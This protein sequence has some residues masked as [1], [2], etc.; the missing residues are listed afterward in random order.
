MAIDG[1]LRYLLCLILIPLFFTSTKAQFTINKEDW[2]RPFTMSK[3]NVFTSV[4]SS[5]FAGGEGITWNIQNQQSIGIQTID[6]QKQ[7]WYLNTDLPDSLLAIQWGNRDTW[8]Y[9]SRNSG[10]HL[11]GMIQSGNLWKADAPSVRIPFPL[12]YGS[13]HVLESTFSYTKDTSFLLVIDSVRRE[14][15]YLQT[16]TTPGYGNFIT[17]GVPKACMLVREEIIMSDT[18]SY[19]NSFTGWFNSLVQPEKDTLVNFY[20]MSNLGGFLPAVGF[21]YNGEYTLWVSTIEPEPSAINSRLS[22]TQ[23]ASP[24]PFTSGI[25]VELKEPG[26]HIRVIDLQGKVV[27]QFAQLPAGKINLPLEELM[28]GTYYLCFTKKPNQTKQILKIP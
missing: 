10:I 28:P 25:S 7:A 6:I 2:L 19:H 18:I 3:Y 17:N 11:Q 5:F 9:T 12:L 16:I 24:N 20:W 15:S 13:T 22:M 27:K 1:R 8:L 26:E 4:D 21:L 14:R 23:E